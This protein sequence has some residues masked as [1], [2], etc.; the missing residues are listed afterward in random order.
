MIIQCSDGAEVKAHRSAPW[1][2]PR[3]AFSR[4]G[5]LSGSMVFRRSIQG[6]QLGEVLKC[7]GVVF[8]GHMMHLVDSFVV[9]KPLSPGP[10]ETKPETSYCYSSRIAASHHQADLFKSNIQAKTCSG[11]G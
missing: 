10:N 11:P 3:H 1:E 7:T 5:S 2:D 6:F 9:Y 4:S 8:T